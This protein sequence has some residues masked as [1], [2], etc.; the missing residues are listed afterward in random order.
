MAKVQHGWEHRSINEVEQLAAQLSPRAHML[1]SPK[2][3]HQHSRTLSNGLMN[4][5]DRLSLLQRS[6]QKGQ[7]GRGRE[8]PVEND[9]LMSPP[10][11]RRSGVYQP[12]LSPQRSQNTHRAGLG[13]PAELVKTSSRDTAHHAKTRPLAPVNGNSL[14]TTPPS[15][16]AYEP[17]TPKSIHRPATIRTQIQTAQAEQD[18]MDALLLMGSPKRTGHP[19]NSFASQHSS[20]QQSPVS[21]TF[22]AS[23]PQRALLYRND[24]SG[25]DSVSSHSEQAIAIPRQARADNIEAH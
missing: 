14:T 12:V 9:A 10:S 25:S 8:R 2:G 5:A 20:S 16:R 13:P 15:T 1:P 21:L 24:S 7:Y 4:G 19:P 23:A 3:H 18:A 22:G 11:K 17:A 6:P